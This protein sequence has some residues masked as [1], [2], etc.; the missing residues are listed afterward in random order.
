[1]TFSTAQLLST[2][3][4]YPK[5]KTYCVAYSGGLDSTVLLHLLATCRD[6]L[7][8]DVQAVHVNHGLQAEAKS[9]AQHCQH[10]CDALNVPL[11]CIAVDIDKKSG[12]GIEAAA[13]TARYEAFASL[14]KKDDVLC[15][16]HHQDDQAET[17]LLQLLRGAG[18]AGL[19]A[20]PE[21]KPFAAGS[22]LR[23]LLQLS[24]SDLET[25][26][27]R[28]AL[29]WIED[30]S[31]EQISFDRN[32]LRHE[33]MPVIQKRWAAASKTLARGS[34][35]LAEANHLLTDMAE[36]DW[37]AMSEVDNHCM[38]ITRLQALSLSRQ[39][40]VMRF[41]LNKINK[42]PIPDTQRLSQ[43]FSEVIDA[44]EDAEPCIQWQGIAIRRY[45]QTLYVTAS[46]LPQAAALAW[47]L[48]QPLLIPEINIRLNAEQTETD[49]LEKSLAE[50]NDNRIDFRRGGETCR[51]VGRGGQRHELKKLMQEWG[52]PPWKRARVPLLYVADEIA[53][54]VGYCICEGFAAPAG[55]QGIDIK[56]EDL[57][58]GSIATASENNDNSQD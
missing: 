10:V 45:R 18:V 44:A 54:V 36:Q 56:T 16:A 37:L 33:V 27:K 51:P 23:P 29:K 14:I 4:R 12:K 22:M 9:W 38:S 2:L 17:L 24:R 58:C 32:Y 13:R 40:N 55:E 25:Y 21:A 42:A 5:P 3:A 35:H 30:P 1:M 15:L 19:A 47:N 8:A 31:N 52:V 7:C 43:I 28:H 26:A 11:T 39:R 57:S 6:D 34:S 48:S 50:R 46:E 49:G 53:S 41:W 20:M